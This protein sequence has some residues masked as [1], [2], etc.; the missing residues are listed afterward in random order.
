MSPLDPGTGEQYIGFNALLCYCRDDVLDCVAIRHFCLLNP[1]LS[2]NSVN[3][4]V[5]CGRVGRVSLV[6]SHHQLAS[7]QSLGVSSRRGLGI[8]YLNQN[9][10]GASF[11]EP[12]GHCLSNSSGSARHKRRSTAQREKRRRHFLCC[13]VICSEL[14]RINGCRGSMEA[15]SV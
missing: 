1:G 2:P 3:N 7:R 14:I 4:F 12:N 13:D 9:N 10:V 8:T 5:S 6:A 11:C 15:V